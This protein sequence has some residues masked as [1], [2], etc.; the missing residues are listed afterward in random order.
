MSSGWAPEIGAVLRK[1]WLV[2]RRSKSGL[3]TAFLSSVLTVISIAYGAFAA[4]LSGTL[5]AGL[6]WVALIFAAVAALPRTFLAEEEASTADL[7][8]LFARPHAVFW[9]KAIFNF[10]EMILTSAVLAVL[11]FALMDLHIEYPL[12]FMLSVF[13][14]AAALAGTVTFCA[15]LVAQGSNRS[16]LVGVISLPVLIPLIMLGIS[17]CRVA[18]G[19]GVLNGGVVSCAGLWLYGAAVYAVAPN[20]FAVIWRQA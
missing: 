15:A 6:F 14:G 18:L 19:E 4:K 13:G 20:L 8:R 12:L 9:G 10:L 1:E 5:G 17:S 16:S 11:F 2:E 3:L 7:M